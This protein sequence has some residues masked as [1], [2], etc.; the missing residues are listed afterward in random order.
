MDVYRPMSLAATAVMYAQ[1]HLAN[2][3]SFAEWPLVGAFTFW[4]DAKLWPH[5][6]MATFKIGTK[7]HSG[8]PYTKYS[9]ADL[10]V[11][12]DPLRTHSLAKK[13]L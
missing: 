6:K 13:H 4:N 3:L 1:I 5:V 2:E 9:D 10:Q 8:S 7:S 12:G 11:R